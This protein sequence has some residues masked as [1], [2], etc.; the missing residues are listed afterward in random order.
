LLG[1]FGLTSEFAGGGPLGAEA[2]DGLLGRLIRGPIVE[3]VAAARPCPQPAA[4]E[5]LDGGVGVVAEAGGHPG[6]HETF[7]EVACGPGAGARPQRHGA[8]WSVEHFGV[9][10]ERVVDLEPSHQ[11]APDKITASED[12]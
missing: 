3:P 7:G 4:Y 10:V 9:V 5:F 12:A 11:A 1:G 6:R 2:L 8:V